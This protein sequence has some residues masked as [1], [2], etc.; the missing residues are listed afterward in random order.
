M[1]RRK[2]VFL[3]A[4]L[5]WLIFTLSCPTLCLSRLA[6]TRW[7]LKTPLPFI[8]QLVSANGRQRHYIRG[9]EERGEGVFVLPHSLPALLWFWQSLP[10]LCGHSFCLTDGCD[11]TGPAVD[12]ETLSGPISTWG[13]K[14]FLLLVG[15]SIS[16]PL[17]D[18]LF[19]AHTSSYC[20][21]I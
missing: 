16:P 9:Q 17:V 10:S 20:T 18:F 12:L 3:F 2:L 7:I 13:I 5:T 14:S 4:S 11:S 6:S 8:F 21:F 15:L 1:V 19:P